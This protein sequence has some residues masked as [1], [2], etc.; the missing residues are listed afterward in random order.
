MPGSIYL[1]RKLAH[2]E[3]AEGATDDLLD[4]L[5]NLAGNFDL[6]LFVVIVI[7]VGRDLPVLADVHVVVS[8]PDTVLGA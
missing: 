7:H 8:T 4:R 5:A 2:G 6:D 1:K 3:C